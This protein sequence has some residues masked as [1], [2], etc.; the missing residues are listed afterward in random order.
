[1]VATE[2]GIVYWTGGSDELSV[3]NTSNVAAIAAGGNTKYIICHSSSSSSATSLMHVFSTAYETQQGSMSKKIARRSSSMLPKRTLVRALDLKYLRL[4]RQNCVESK[5]YEPAV[6]QMLE[7]FSNPAALNICFTRLSPKKDTLQGFLNFDAIQELYAIYADNV[8]VQNSIYDATHNGLL[9]IEGVIKDSRSLPELRCLIIL[10][11]NPLYLDRK[12]GSKW[13]NRYLKVCQ[14]FTKMKDGALWILAEVFIKCV[15]RKVVENQVIKHMVW[16]FCNE[17]KL[18]GHNAVLQNGVA[19]G[20]VNFLS[21]LHK[22]K[23]L[24]IRSWHYR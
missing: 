13:A 10:L 9:R 8:D 22:A 21:H 3:K 16:L 17:M 11:L 7:L 18:Q 1:M 19:L 24:R 20:V 14:L 4:V 23:F 12:V 6:Q 15:P 2:S 5:N